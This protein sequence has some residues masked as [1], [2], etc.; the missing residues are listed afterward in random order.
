[1]IA[2]H[3]F[4]MD[5]LIYWVG[6]VIGIIVM[7]PLLLVHHP[8]QAAALRGP[9][10]SR[11][12]IAQLITL[13]CVLW[14][15]FGWDVADEFKHFYPLFLPLVWIAMRHGLKGATL[16]IL[17]IQL[18]LIVFVQSIE[19]RSMTVLELQI[20]MFALDSTGLFLG[21]AVNERQ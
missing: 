10:G 21:I 4:L 18:G 7:A 8:V 6:D 1:L 15:V 13:L 2:P 9:L 20:L 5:V 14:L 11:E 19:H 16:A 3:E 12:N 17:A